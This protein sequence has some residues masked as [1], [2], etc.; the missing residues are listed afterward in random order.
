M[1][2]DNPNFMKTFFASLVFASLFFSACGGKVQDEVPV[3]EVVEQ[4]TE[5]PEVFEFSR[6]TTV[7]SASSELADNSGYG[8]EYSASNV[9]DLD[10]ST[11]WCSVP[12]VDPELSLTFPGPVEL[13]TVGIVGGF[14]RD[15]KIY[16]EN[17]RIK[18]LEIW[19]DDRQM[20]AQIWNFED[21]YAMQ[22]FDLP[23]GEFQKLNLKI[24]ETYPG[25]KY[26]DS[27]MAEIDFWS[28]YVKQKDSDAAYNYYQDHKANAAVRP[29]G[30]DSMHFFSLSGLG[31]YSE[32]CGDLYETPQ[33][34]T[35]FFRSPGLYA[36]FNEEAKEGDLIVMKVTEK[37]PGTSGEGGKGSDVLLSMHDTKI[38]T[39]EDGNLVIW[40]PM[41]ETQF[42]P[43]VTSERK[44]WLY[45]QDKLIGTRE[46]TV[47]GAQ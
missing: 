35:D 43:S 9:L 41:A 13:G 15:E 25:S 37:H 36:I 31:Q 5:A 8:F 17:N 47:G 27:C 19:P 34:L 33:D 2:L 7:V 28:D 42:E 38:K 6:E 29:V 24:T 10:Y 21:R 1:N 18:T 45:Y 12:G 4:E 20:A 26:A 46:F 16:F 3:V 40:E 22:F 11:A 44:V 23:K 39:C 32:T 30:V 14:A